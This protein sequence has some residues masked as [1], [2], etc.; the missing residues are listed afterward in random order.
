MPRQLLRSI[1][2]DASDAE[3][4]DTASTPGEWAVT[5]AFMFLND[6]DDSLVGKRLQAFRNGFL[7]VQ[8]F[9]WST[10]AEVAEISDDEYRTVVQQLA[11]GLITHL[12][13]P[14]LDAAMPVATAEADYA[15]AA[16]EQPVGTLIALSR[17]I[18]DE[19]IAENL[20]IVKPAPPG[21]DALKI[22]EWSPDEQD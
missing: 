2:L 13:A 20:H 19:G 1:R 9:G 18:T 7:G 15:A 5:G 10:L 14:D 12:G 8:S 4:F 6:T 3:V 11:D 16:C 22:W 17:E 21:H